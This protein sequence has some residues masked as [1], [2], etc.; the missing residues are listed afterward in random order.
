METAVTAAARGH[1]VIVLEKESRVGGQIWLGAASPL[2]KDWSRIAEYYQRMSQTGRFEVRLNTPAAP[3][4]ILELR[5]DA[6]VVATGSKPL[7]LEIL[8]GSAA[9]TIH[10]ALTGAAQKARRVAIYDREGFNRPIVVADYLSSRG[11]SVEFITSFVEVGPLVEPMMRQEMIEHFSCRGVKFA[12]AENIVGW[13]ALGILRTRSN[14]TGEERT[15]VGIDAVVAA[16]GSRSVEELTAS[17]RTGVVELHVIGDAN[18]PQTVEHA[19]YQGARIG[20]LL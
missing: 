1:E 8:N 13:D 18:Q 4:S 16:N 2:R 11:V 20:R 3:K 14:L 19:T 15:L 7:R 17:L 10:E 5:P 12:C 9:L 6:V